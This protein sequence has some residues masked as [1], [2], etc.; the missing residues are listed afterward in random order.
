[1]YRYYH[2]IF[3]VQTQNT[4]YHKQI[5]IHLKIEQHIDYRVWTLIILNL[6]LNIFA[7]ILSCQKRYEFIYLDFL[8]SL[9]HYIY[10]RDVVT[11]LD[12]RSRGPPYEPVSVGPVIFSKD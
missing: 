3:V 12:I 8:H 10:Y 9:T 4:I 2:S 6:F 11:M 7:C 1:M 5:V